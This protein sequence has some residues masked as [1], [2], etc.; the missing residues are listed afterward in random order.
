MQVVCEAT[1][2]PDTRVSEMKCLVF[3]GKA[4]NKWEMLHEICNNLL[5]DQCVSKYSNKMSFKVRSI[6]LLGG[7]MSLVRDLIRCGVN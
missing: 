1:Q 2:C 5:N 4:A 7:F 3:L 6:K